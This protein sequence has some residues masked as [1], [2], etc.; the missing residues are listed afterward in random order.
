MPKLTKSTKPIR[1]KEIKRDWH[2]I[3]V[4]GQIL[5]RVS[6]R[7]ALLLQGKNKP[8]Y[9]SYLDM[10][11]NVVV[12]NSKKIVVSGNKR[13][14]KVYYRYSGYPGGLKKITYK[15]LMEKNP[16]EVIKRAV[17]GMLPKN[18]LRKKRMLRLFVFSDDN[19]PYKDKF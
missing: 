16:N 13:N 19:H 4:K 8:N 1:K 5:G 7:I 14:T 3:D 15:Q 12:I 2:L 9:V 18:K 17:K 10:G 11:D 6:S